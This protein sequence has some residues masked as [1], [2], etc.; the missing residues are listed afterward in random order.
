M[1]IT[2]DLDELMLIRLDRVAEEQGGRDMLIWRALSQWF[3]RQEEAYRESRRG[4]AE[5]PEEVLNFKGIPDLVPFES[6][7]SE[8]LEPR[9]E[10]EE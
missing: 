5:W 9:R 2:I 8:F 7:R 1:K 10:S 6:Y 4:I 3:T